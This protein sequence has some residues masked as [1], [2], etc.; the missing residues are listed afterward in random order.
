MKPSEQR[1]KEL[2]KLYFDFE[3]SESERNELWEYI[4]DPVYEEQVQAYIPDATDNRIDDVSIAPDKEQRILNH[5]FS[6]E[7]IPHSIIKKVRLWHWATIAAAVL[8]ILIG[9]WF[10]DYRMKNAPSTTRDV[11]VNTIGPGK[12]SAILTLGNGKKI[13]LNN[14]ANGPVAKQGGVRIF[15][16]AEGIVYQ[17]TGNAGDPEEMNTLSTNKGETYELRL[18][19]G[20]LVALN[21]MSSLSYPTNFISLKQRRVKLTGEAYF[22]VSKNKSRP[23][24][25]ETGQ[26]EV[27]VLGTKFNVNS[28]RDE[29]AFT[30]TLV[31][32]SVKV[33]S[34]TNRK[35][36]HPG[37]QV[38]NANGKMT[39]TKVNLENIVDWK[40][41]DFNLTGLDFPQA[42]R[43]IARWYDVEMIYDP[44]LPKNIQADGWISRKQTLNAV[45][46][47]IQKIGIVKFRVDGRKVYVSPSP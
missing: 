44:S 37:E 7:K 19:D 46:D 33:I 29:A 35:V 20:T 10:I 42:M 22:Q 21:A 36:I 24:I 16:S 6:Y 40:D 26:Q 4:N 27:E 9:T 47:M 1:L 11:A 32:G 14:A 28:Y 2:M 45:L 13:I 43:K 15:K 18:P 31:E 34:G 12:Y 25:V 38:R 3:I 8:M 23:F 17:L 5:I 39:I 41:G 30:T